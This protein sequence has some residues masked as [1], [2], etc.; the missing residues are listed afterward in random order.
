MRN[1]THWGMG[2]ETQ[3]HAALLKTWEH[4]IIQHTRPIQSRSRGP[5]AGSPGETVQL[6]SVPA[7][8]YPSEQ[9]TF[10]HPGLSENLLD[11]STEQSPSSLGKCVHSHRSCVSRDLHLA[12]K[13][14]KVWLGL[15]KS[16]MELMQVK[17][18]SG[19]ELGHSQLKVCLELAH[20]RSYKEA[21]I[22]RH[23]RMLPFK[24]CWP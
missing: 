21:L 20:R 5:T 17:D 2:E 14:E 16:R 6:H 22:L 11:T 23:L 8:N 15:E 18:I 9:G 24:Y 13:T 12:E 10:S 19:W 3:A 4:L 1:K 7:S